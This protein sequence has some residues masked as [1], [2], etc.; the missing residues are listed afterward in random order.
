MQ[1]DHPVA[2][3]LGLEVVARSLAEAQMLTDPLRELGMGVQ[4]G[5]RRGA[6]ERDL[7]SPA[8]RIAD[9]VAAERH[10]S[11]VAGKLLAEGHG[12]RV[13]HVGPARLYEVRELAGLAM[14]R[15]G[16]ALER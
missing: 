9:A 11:R 6:A 13:H 16:Q 10:L 8:E 2:V 5:A 15:A 3:G 12:D 14:E 1:L 4:A 7:G